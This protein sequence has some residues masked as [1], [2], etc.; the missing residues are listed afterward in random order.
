MQL[1]P[2]PIQQPKWLRRVFD[3]KARD[4]HIDQGNGE[5]QHQ[6]DVVQYDRCILVLCPVYVQ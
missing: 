5:H 2:F 4:D 3:A 1:N 6:Y